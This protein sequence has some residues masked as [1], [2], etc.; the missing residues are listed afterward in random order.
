MLSYLVEHFGGAG[1]EHGA[2]CDTEHFIGD[3][4]NRLAVAGAAGDMHIVEHRIDKA[5]GFLEYLQ[6]VV[7]TEETVVLVVILFAGAAVLLAV[8]FV[9]EHLAG[10]GGNDVLMRCSV[11]GIHY[12]VGKLLGV[13]NDALRRRGAVNACVVLCILCAEVAV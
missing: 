12:L 8:L 10:R 11:F 3:D 2:A 6:N 13:A 9:G 4:I 1:I 7:G 5:K